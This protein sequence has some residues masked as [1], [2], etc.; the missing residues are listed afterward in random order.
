MAY[1][2]SGSALAQSGDMETFTNHL[3]N[4]I[5]FVATGLASTDSFRVEV[6][7]SY[8][9]V[10]TTLFRIWADDEGPRANNYD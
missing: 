8:E 3:R 1:N 9:F 4:S 2:S 7:I 5:Y 10:P 6:K